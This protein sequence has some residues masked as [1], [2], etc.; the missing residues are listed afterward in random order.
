MSVPTLVTI[1]GSLRPES[2]NMN[3]LV[4]AEEAATEL[5]LFQSIARIDFSDLPYYDARI[6]GSL[7]PAEVLASRDIA[8]AADCLLI[9]TPEYNASIPGMLKNGID[10]LSRPRG[11]AVLSG[12][13]TA[14]IS[15]SPGAGG[16]I[17]GQEH[18]RQVLLVA[19]AQVVDHAPVV[20][21]GA[22]DSAMV[23]ADT[24]VELHSLLSALAQHARQ[25]AAV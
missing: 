8:A 5:G 18:L 12:K 11:S 25:V 22:G 23:P 3:L 4:Q 2:V 7:T 19:G 17:R 15:A 10:W 6:E 16:G 24:R 21:A 1:T 9:A 14:V 20:W 13:S